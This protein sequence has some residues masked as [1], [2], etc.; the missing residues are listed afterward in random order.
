MEHLKIKAFG[1][2]EDADV[3]FGDLTLLVGPQASGKSIFI[4][5]LKL[6]VDKYHIRKTLQQYNYIWGKDTEKILDIYFGEGMSK[7]WKTNT[8][9]QLDR[10]SY[11]KSFLL[12]KAGRYEGTSHAEETLFYIPAQRILSISDG[13]PKTF[14]EFDSSTPYVL[15]QFKEPGR[16]NSEWKWK[17]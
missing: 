17:E 6:L 4:Q 16:K 3:N 5:L 11:T 9:I 13:R 8:N 2:I 14:M 7:I 1:P 12:P 15:R 10:K